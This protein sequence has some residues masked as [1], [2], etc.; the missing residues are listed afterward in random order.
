MSGAWRLPLP[1]GPH[2]AYLGSTRVWIRGLQYYRG[3]ATP[4]ETVRLMREPA[5]A[6]DFNAICALN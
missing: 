2:E 1:Q 4:G 5:N 6:Y 3:V